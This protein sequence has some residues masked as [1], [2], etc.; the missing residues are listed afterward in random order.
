M[1][2]IQKDITQLGIKQ[3]HYTVAEMEDKLE[4]VDWLTYEHTYDL[5]EDKEFEDSM[6]VT[7]ATYSTVKDCWLLKGTCTIIV[8]HSGSY[9]LTITA[10]SDSSAAITAN[11][12]T[13]YPENG[14]YMI[15]LPDVQAVIFETGDG[16]YISKIKV[17][18]VAFTPATASSDG[19]FHHDDKEKLD[20][21]YPAIDLTDIYT[22]LVERSEGVS[23]VRH[24]G[25]TEVLLQQASRIFVSISSGSTYKVG[26]YDCKKIGDNLL[27][28]D[29]WDTAGE[30]L[31][32]HALTYQIDDAGISFASVK[33][34]VIAISRNSETAK[35]MVNRMNT[36]EDSLN[37]SALP[38]I[39]TLKN[40]I[41]LDKAALAQ[42]S[43][44]GHTHTSID[45]PDATDTNFASKPVGILEGI[46]AG[47]L[48]TIS[49]APV[50]K[51]GFGMLKLPISKED[52]F[53]RLLITES[54]AFYVN[55]ASDNLGDPTEWLQ[56]LNN[57]T[58]YVAE[59]EVSI[60][61]AKTKFARQ[62]HTH[63]QADIID[64]SHDWSDILNKPT[65]FAPSA[66]T[67]LVKE[68][69]D[70]PQSLKNP[71]NL[72][73]YLNGARQA[74]YDGSA[75]TKVDITP[76]AIGA[77]PTSHSHKAK[78]VKDSNY[79]LTN[80][81][82]VVLAITSS[83]DI[84]MYAPDSP[85]T[86]QVYTII[87][88]GT[89]HSLNLQFKVNIAGTVKNTLSISEAGASI[90]LVYGGDG[91]WYGSYSKGSIS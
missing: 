35:E 25:V 88:H 87:H 11:G 15:P 46:T 65:S 82:F 57:K 90:T 3:I 22:D 63:T 21:M 56:L 8:P 38:D 7:T 48:D 13:Y 2:T 43:D 55:F 62:S 40:E 28:F 4:L 69:T 66:H 83:Y 89:S 27:C 31:Y 79:T 32:R 19:L 12:Q 75:E 54:G 68:I 30:Y 36:V 81:D 16:V 71:T 14:V 24:S 91:V 10:G 84:S 77:A 50:S 41:T 67:H 37:N 26:V 23:A 74:S 78:I 34:D 20:K 5:S 44:K 76:T 80:L 1:T 58:S 72:N 17:K 18:G 85:E 70:F 39:Q 61:G 33:S 86:G 9:Y 47:F 51:E 53:A 42:K 45:I 60:D 6:S 59:D 49:G 29:C 52:A 73:V 64:L